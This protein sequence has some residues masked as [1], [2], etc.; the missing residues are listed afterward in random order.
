[1]PISNGFFAQQN[2]NFFPCLQELG[3]G[4][5]AKLMTF[6][7]V[8]V[9]KNTPDTIKSYLFNVFKKI[10]DD[11][12]FKKLPDMG[13][14]DPRWGGPDFVRQKVKDAEEVG[15]PVLKEL[16]LYTGK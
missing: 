13:G 9:H 15:I 7:A 12:R 6:G 1:M 14:E 10:Y 4:Q 8:W 11:P 5:A 3:Y 2:L 16:G